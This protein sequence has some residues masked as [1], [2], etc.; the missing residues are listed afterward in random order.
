MEIRRACVSLIVSQ[1][2]CL[3]LDVS[4]SYRNAE[5]WPFHR[6]GSG[7]WF[8]KLFFL[9]CEVDG[10]RSPRRNQ[11]PRP[12][13]TQLPRNQTRKVGLWS[14]GLQGH[15]CHKQVSVFMEVDPTGGWAVLS[16]S[17]P[18]RP[19]RGQQHRAPFL[20]HRLC[21]HGGTSLG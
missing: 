17:M 15:P 5:Q 7:G 13:Q 21:L 20:T 12:F 11:R 19:M 8:P 3:L 1:Q 16:G 2:T 4:N 9:H 6:Q 14:N 18:L 10:S